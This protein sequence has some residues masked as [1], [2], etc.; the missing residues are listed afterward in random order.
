MY[1]INFFI[2]KAM[3]LRY[4]PP[5]ICPHCGC[6]NILSLSKDGGSICMCNKCSNMLRGDLLPKSLNY[7][8]T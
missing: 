5:P 6:A 2:P 8:M 7:K 3:R 1:R 4:H